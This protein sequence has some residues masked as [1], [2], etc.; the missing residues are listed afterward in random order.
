MINDQGELAITIETDENG[1]NPCIV[2]YAHPKDA[3]GNQIK[4]FENKEDLRGGGV[5]QHAFGGET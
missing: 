2:G 1:L 3:Q 5:P 4:G